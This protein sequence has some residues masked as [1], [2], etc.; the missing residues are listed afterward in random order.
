[1]WLLYILRWLTHTAREIFRNGFAAVYNHNLKSNPLRFLAVSL[2]LSEIGII[3]YVC[4]SPRVTTHHPYHK[5]LISGLP[6]IVSVQWHS[7]VSYGPH[8]LQHSK[9]PC[10]SPTP[11]VYSNS[12]PSSWWCHPTIS[13]S[14]FSSS[15]SPSTFTLFHHQVFS[16][17]SVLHIM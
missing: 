3:W 11:R 13:S 5:I 6:F 12:G 4:L 14:V 15:S 16:Y 2:I 10:P 7:H 17:E 8:G 9:F 1:M